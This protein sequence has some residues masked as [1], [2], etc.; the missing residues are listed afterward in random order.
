MPQK[1]THSRVYECQAAP[2]L[3]LKNGSNTSLRSRICSSVYKNQTK[4]GA[5]NINNYDIRYG[6]LQQ[7]LL[8]TPPP[9]RGHE[10]A[11]PASCQY[12]CMAEVA[13][14]FG[15]LPLPQR[16]G[17]IS[18]AAKFLRKHFW[19]NVLDELV[20][21]RGRI[22]DFHLRPCL[23]H[24]GK[25]GQQHIA[26][27]TYAHIVQGVAHRSIHVVPGN[28]KVTFYFMYFLLLW[29]CGRES[30]AFSARMPIQSEHL[31]DVPHL[32]G[33]TKSIEPRPSQ[34]RPSICAQ[35]KWDLN[36]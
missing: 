20:G 8:R 21:L 27:V 19:R 4:Y 6:H 24:G 23:L 31:A 29:D 14:R 32:Q 7:H 1:G 15:L 10:K 2:Q 30:A 5:G 25:G 26:Y 9:K 12:R 11:R 22:N 17:Q 18:Q 33:C 35:R 28:A 3:K 13:P 36:V 34:A 16:W